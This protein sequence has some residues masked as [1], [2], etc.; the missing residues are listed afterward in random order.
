M[1][2]KVCDRSGFL[3]NGDTV[4]ITQGHLHNF[5]CEV[6]GTIPQATI[7]W[8]LGEELQPTND[9]TTTTSGGEN[10]LIN[11][12]SYWSIKPIK[13]HHDM[14]LKCTAST[15]QLRDPTPAIQIKLHGK[16]TCTTISTAQSTS[17]KGSGHYW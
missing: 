10:E 2:I 9:S 5:S 8:Y 11:T 13:R 7:H 6:Q 12:T 17:V 14:E 4:T 1:F 16:H 15:P 3:A